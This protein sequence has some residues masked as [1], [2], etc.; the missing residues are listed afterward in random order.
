MPKKS[1]K[2][3]SRPQ[4]DERSL[5]GAHASGKAALAR[6]DAAETDRRLDAA[7]GRPESLRDYGDCIRAA[8]GLEAKP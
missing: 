3:L 5:R 7:L 2:N 6:M 1:Y 4:Y 8:R